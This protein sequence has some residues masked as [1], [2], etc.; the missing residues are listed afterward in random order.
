M[1]Q[2]SPPGTAE[3]FVP[4]PPLLV[5]LLK[6]GFSGLAAYFLFLAYQLSKQIIDQNTTDAGVL[7]EKRKTL[8]FY[9]GLCAGALILFIVSQFVAQEKPVP[10][11][12]PTWISA[13]ALGQASDQE[14]A[15]RPI[16]LSTWQVGAEGTTFKSLKLTRAPQ[17]VELPSSGGIVMISIPVAPGASASAASEPAASGLA[18]VSP[19]TPKLSE[20]R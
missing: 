9:G 12:A 11:P 14:L 17:T 6:L 8:N 13:S 4:M 2:R 20:E 15:T 5:D 16:E 7:A 1:S 19:E 18:Q 10:T 3:V